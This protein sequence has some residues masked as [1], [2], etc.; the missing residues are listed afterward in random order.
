MASKH[1]G[2]F[3]L[4][5]RQCLPKAESLSNSHASVEPLLCPALLWF[6]NQD[7]EPGTGKALRGLCEI[8]TY[9]HRG[10]RDEGKERGR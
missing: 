2:H 7:G 5:G 1:S 4:T 6:T 9:Q 8:S 10:G 3:L